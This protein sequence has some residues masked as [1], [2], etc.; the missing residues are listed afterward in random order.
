[1]A[2]VPVGSYDSLAALDAAAIAPAPA[3]ASW[4]ENISFTQGGSLADQLGASF[5]TTQPGLYLTPDD[6][7]TFSVWNSNAALTSIDLVLRVL[8]P[9]GTLVMTRM[10]ISN[11]THD[12]TANVA[13]MA[14]LEGFLV[15][16]IVSGVN[17]GVARG[18]CY[19]R[20]QITRGSPPD[21]LVVDQ[22]FAD[23]VTTGNSPQWPEGALLSGVDGHGYFT[24]YQVGAAAQ[25]AEI[26][27][28]QPAGV[29]WRVV[30][31]TVELATSGQAGNRTVSFEIFQGGTL[32]YVVMGGVPLPPNTVGIWSLASGVSLVTALQSIMTVPLPVDFKISNQASIS[33]VTLGL[34]NLDRWE[35]LQVQV[36]EWIDV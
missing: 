3:P 8:K 11:L 6:T 30:A 33:T 13:Q 36:E 16:C 15:S 25:G 19:T 29:R 32:V 9:D 31:I 17:V 14:Q 23:Y 24:H 2:T 34:Q 26:T 20:A 10:G 18:Q 7:I 22:L 28:Q 21:V 4:P 27:L 1:M 35:F 12:I 5:T